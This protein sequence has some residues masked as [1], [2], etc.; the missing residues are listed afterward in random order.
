[1]GELWRIK[2]GR[3]KSKKKCFAVPAF[4]SMRGLQL[5]VQFSRSHGGK[6]QILSQGV[7]SAG[8]PRRGLTLL[9]GILWWSRA[10]SWIEALLCSPGTATREEKG[11]QHWLWSQYNKKK[12]FCQV[13]QSKIQSNDLVFVIERFSILFTCLIL[14]FEVVSM[15]ILNH[16]RDTFWYCDTQYAFLYDWYHHII[17]IVR[18]FRALFNN[19]KNKLALLPWRR[20]WHLDI[21]HCTQSF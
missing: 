4:Q 8:W 21:N 19:K 12:S 3:H 16:N 6:C 9:F 10:T 13:K 2:P 5:I 14:L 11:V 18:P 1:M 20:L 7:K 15:K 17:D